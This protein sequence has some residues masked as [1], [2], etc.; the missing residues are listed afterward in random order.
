MRFFHGKKKKI[1]LHF[2]EDNDR[3]R[4]NHKKTNNRVN[5]IY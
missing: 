1:K 3:G 4:L 5:L 2:F